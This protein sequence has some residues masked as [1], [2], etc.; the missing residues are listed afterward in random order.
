[1]ED[2]ILDIWRLWN[3]V[4]NCRSTALFGGPKKPLTGLE[5]ESRLQLG[6]SEKASTMRAC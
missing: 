3:N 5:A 4:T 1:L 6:Q 2:T